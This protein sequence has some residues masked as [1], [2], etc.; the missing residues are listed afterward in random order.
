MLQYT[1]ST[2]AM[3]KLLSF[4]LQQRGILAGRPGGRKPISSPPPP[5]R[6]GQTT[7]MQTRLSAVVSAGM[8]I[9]RECAGGRPDPWLVKNLTG[10]VTL[11]CAD[12]AGLQATPL[13]GN[14]R[15]AGPA[16]PASPLRLRPT[17]VY[18]L[19]AP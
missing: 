18:H 16:V 13:D 6:P 5:D 19:I 7:D 15:A 12:V 11:K 1:T 2:F 4:T 9:A 10:T 17:T 3:T 14:G 8:H